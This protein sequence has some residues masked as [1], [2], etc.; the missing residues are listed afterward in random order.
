MT[1]GT[2]RSAAANQARN[3]GRGS[4]ARCPGTARRA[5]RRRSARRGGSGTR[6]ARRQGPVEHHQAAAGT[7]GRP[8]G[9]QHRRRVGQLV[10]GVL[11]VGEVVLAALAGIGRPRPGG[12]SIRSSSPAADTLARARATESASNSTPTSSQRREAARHR[13]EPPAATAMDVHDA[14]TVC[15]VDDE[16]R[17][18]GQRLLEEDPDV[19]RRQAFDGDAVAVRPLADRFARSGRSRASRPSRAKRP[20]HGRT[21]RRGTQGCPRRG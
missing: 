13:D 15:Q 10:E 12:S 3:C 20:S 2:G 14:A 17:E 1:V 16:L 5:G 11:E 6:R 18:R 8:G 7:Q 4:P 19:L 21:G 9:S